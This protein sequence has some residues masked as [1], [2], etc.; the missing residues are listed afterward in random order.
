MAETQDNNVPACK[1]YESYGF[2]LGGF[3][4]Y[5]YKGIDKTNNEIA[6]F[7]YYFNLH[8]SYFFLYISL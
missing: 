6:I 4:K 7:W 3:D 1:F 8:D 5:L 2:K